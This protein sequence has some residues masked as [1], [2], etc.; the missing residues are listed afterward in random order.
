MLSQVGSLENLN[1]L[2]C[3]L[4]HIDDCKAEKQVAR[5]NDY[6]Q[7]MLKALTGAPSILKTLHIINRPYEPQPSL[8]GNPSFSAL[9]RTLRTLYLAFDGSSWNRISGCRRLEFFTHLPQTWLAP[10]ST[11][12]TCL[13]LTATAQ[14]GYLVKVDFRSVHF[15]RL[16]SLKMQ[17]F[18]VQS[19]LAA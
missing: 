13:T 17:N 7:R 16:R 5:M 18:Y 1:V 2:A 8:T 19:R 14:W 11:N 15:P 10:T 4:G 6:R 3:G 9:L 12:L